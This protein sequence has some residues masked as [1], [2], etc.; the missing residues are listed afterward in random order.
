[1][2]S[3][4]FAIEPDG[5]ERWQA[6][7]A[8]SV[9]TVDVDPTESV[10]VLGTSGVLTSPAAVVGV[11]PQDGGTL[12]R[13]ELPVEDPQVP[14]PW[15]GGSG[16]NQYIDSKADFAAD[17][18][19]AYLQTAIAPG[20]VVTDRAFLY[21]VDLDP[22]VPTPSELLRSVDIDLSGRSRATGVVIT[23]LVTVQ[24]ESLVPVSGA[25][26]HATWTLPDGSTVT[27][28]GRTN[29]QGQARL[30]R[31][32][33]GGFYTLTI[34]NITKR[35]YTFDPANSVLSQTIAWF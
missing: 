25:I 31:A 29:D 35:D 6:G 13:E 7:L 22:G 18:S 30:R 17:G 14:N 19:A 5:S 15:T 2:S 34:T 20:G 32:G 16:F 21:A 26:V 11:D 28:R 23:G 1:V 10:L 8:E 24:D 12:W 9:G 3:R 27:R 33:E 4:I